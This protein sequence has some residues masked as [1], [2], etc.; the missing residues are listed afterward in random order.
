MDAPALPAEVARAYEDLASLSVD[1]ICVIESGDQDNFNRSQQKSKAY[2]VKPDKIR[3]EQRGGRG[4][5]F[6]SDGALVHNYFA[7]AKRYSKS[8]F[9]RRDRLSG[10]FQSDHPLVGSNPEFLFHEIN[11]RV[12][13]AEILP[14][15]RSGVYEVSVAYEPIAAPMLAS[16]SPVKYW[17]DSRTHLVLR[18]EAE[19]A[20]RIPASDE[21]NAHKKT[22]SFTRVDANAA[23]APE[24]FEYSPPPSAEDA[25]LPPGQGGRISFRGGG[26]GAVAS[27]GQKRVHGGQAF[28]RMVRQDLHSTPQPSIARHGSQL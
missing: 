23:I 26:G 5:V 14:E 2:Y 9:S 21:T 15:L 17:I 25:S 10:W 24:L 12:A 4:S 8:P 27:S 1:V 18:A 6:V 7:Y 3:L 28:V 20:H 19:V 22:V 16:A 11:Q 13:S